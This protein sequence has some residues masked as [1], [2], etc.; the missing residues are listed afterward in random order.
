MLV[1]N[2]LKKRGWGAR[3]SKEMFHAA[4]LDLAKFSFKLPK[5]I[6]AFLQPKKS[7]DVS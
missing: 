4:K 1:I 5:I 2:L 7:P 6:T 3:K